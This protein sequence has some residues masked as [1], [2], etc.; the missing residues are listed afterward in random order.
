[1]VWKENRVCW[2]AKQPSIHEVAPLRRAVVAEEGGLSTVRGSGGGGFSLRARW[3][4]PGG[5]RRQFGGR[6]CSRK[7]RAL[8]LMHSAGQT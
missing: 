2:A 8:P 3:R 1:M 4:D 6:N 5:G 7:P